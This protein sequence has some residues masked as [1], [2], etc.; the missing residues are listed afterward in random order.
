MAN[1]LK[2]VQKACDEACTQRDNMIGERE[3]A[4]DELDEAVRRAAVTEASFQKEEQLKALAAHAAVL[5]S[6]VSDAE[7]KV[8][9]LQEELRELSLKPRGRKA[10]HA[11]RAALEAKWD[12]R[13]KEAQRKAMLR[14][15]HDISKHLEFSACDWE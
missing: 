6:N 1:K 7:K 4:R 15:T 3:R 12:G 11:G 10:G 13:S 9:Q 5:Q 2:E 8:D 14:H